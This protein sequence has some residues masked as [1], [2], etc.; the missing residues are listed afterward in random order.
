MAARASLT[1]PV[2]LL[3]SQAAC[4]RLDPPTLGDGPIAFAPLVGGPEGWVVTLATLPVECPD[5]A[6][7]IVYIVHPEVAT[8][9]MATAVVFHSGSFDWVF[10]ASPNDPLGGP[11]YQPTPRLT[12]SWASRKVFALLG[13]FP[14][15]D[16]MEPSDG[17]LIAALAERDVV[18]VLPA[19]CW[20]DLWHN[21]PGLA[22]NDYEKD[23]FFRQ[24]RVAAEWAWGLAADPAT[25]VPVLGL[26]LPVTPDPD[27]L[28]AIGIGEGGRAVGELFHNLKA[29]TAFV[30]DSPPDDLGWLYAEPAGS[31]PQVG[32]ER[33]FP[34]GPTVVGSLAY[35]PFLSPRS[36][37]LWSSLDP[38]VPAAA[39]EALRTR[40]TPEPEAWIYDS[41]ANQHTHLP[42]DLELSREV[43]AFLLDAAPWDAPDVTAP[44]DRGPLSDCVAVEE[45]DLDVDGALDAITTQTYDLA[46][47]LAEV[48][49]DHDADG[50][51]D[52]TDH[53]V[54]A[55]VVTQLVDEDDDGA[56]DLT[57]TWT[58]DDLGR[59]L[60]RDEDVGSDGSINAQ[61]T[62]SYLDDPLGLPLEI[63]V[64]C[65]DQADGV[66]DSIDRTTVTYTDGP[67]DPKTKVPV[68]RLATWSLDE[69]DN[70]DP[71]E[72]RVYTYGWTDFLY[73]RPDTI[74]EDLDANGVVEAQWTYG[75]SADGLLTFAGHDLGPNDDLDF[76]TTYGWR[77]DGLSDFEQTDYEGDANPDV[78][79]TWTWDDVPKLLMREGDEPID[80]LIDHRY[81]TTW[82]CP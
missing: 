16:P 23:L 3:L 42:A 66:V 15:D 14:S 55:L 46:G 5:G 69:G 51:V 36:V 10:G 71:E 13:M 54:D 74:D 64:A 11:S 31:E 62:Y 38:V 78:L 35:A 75:Y 52:Q 47:D 68:T 56:L 29:P 30:V 34:E 8:E 28:Y 59:P 73:E 9:P 53:V 4:W 32:L 61:C 48:R 17:A 79:W 20:G 76:I 72:V 6:D 33:I 39:T 65:D 22:D 18:S 63:A 40:L 27:R 49:W 82:T 12:A 37:V 57:V 45:G 58:Y 25:F 80:G 19:N 2:L 41:A 81:T 26:T 60:T 44:E 21:Y 70:G 50:V 24:G 1:V 43:V 7:A 67:L 77:D